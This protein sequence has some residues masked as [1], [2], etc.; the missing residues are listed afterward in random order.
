MNDEQLDDLKQFIDA[1]ISQSEQA[2]K[3]EFN[4]R[5]NVT[6]QKIDDGLAGVGEAIEQIDQRLDERD[7]EVDLRLANLEH[8]IAA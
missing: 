3:A 1:R 2:I 7:K 5:L 8:Q 6:N 4:Q